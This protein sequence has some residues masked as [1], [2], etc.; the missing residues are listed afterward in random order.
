MVLVEGQNA[1]GVTVDEDNFDVPVARDAATP[2]AP[3]RVVSAILGTREG[4]AESGYQLA[5]TGVTWT[6]PAAA[7]ALRD[8]LAGRK[9]ESVMLVSAFLAA[10]ALAQTVGSAIGYTQTALL[11]VEPDSAT[12]AVVD[13]ADGSVA[14]V[15]REPLPEDD[16]EAV[17]KLTSMVSGAEALETRPD[18]LV[19]VGSDGVDVAVIK[20]YLEAATSLAVSAP[21]EPEMA[22]ARGAALASANAPLFASSTAAIAYAQDPGT[23]AVDPYA[24]AGYLDVPADAGEGLAYSAVADEGPDAAALAGA[25]NAYTAVAGQEDF[26]TGAYPNFGAEQSEKQHPRTPFLVAMGVLTIFIVGVAA[27]AIALAFAIRPHVDQRPSLAEPKVV[28]PANQAP[29]PPQAPPAPQAPAPAPAPAAPAPAPAA[30]PAPPPAVPPLPAPAAPPVPLPAPPVP[31]P[32]A[33]PV[34]IPA[35]QVPAPAPAPPVPARPPA[36]RIPVPG[37]GVPAGPPAI[38]A[39]HIPVPGIP[40]IPHL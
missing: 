40:G 12:L 20:P 6:D 35:P 21:E 27:L 33:P 22:L 36:P 26:R 29:T 32:A 18:G 2:S 38:P 17:A 25:A 13:T 19:V 4:V 23:G 28:V 30:P 3:D 1:D 16:A 8:A 39:P 9:V 5:S 31:A 24:A 7:A 11:F 14:D 37:P 15:H 34:P 10:A